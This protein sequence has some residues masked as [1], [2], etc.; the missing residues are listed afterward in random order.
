MSSKQR[1]RPRRSD[2]LITPNPTKETA[3][4][5]NKN[6]DGS[7]NAFTPPSIS[8]FDIRIG[9]SYTFHSPIPSVIHND[10]SIPVTLGVDEA[11][12]G[13]VLGILSLSPSNH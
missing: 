10:P 8:P 6:E 4:V 1:G 13:P 9:T 3:T 5:T 11:G 7:V 12:R 2:V